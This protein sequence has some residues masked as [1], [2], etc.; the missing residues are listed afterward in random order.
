MVLATRSNNVLHTICL[1]F[2]SGCFHL[3]SARFVRYCFIDEIF[4]I[5][6][7]QKYCDGNFSYWDPKITTPPGLYYLG[8]LYSKLVNLLNIFNWNL[9]YCGTPVLRSLNLVGGLIVFPIL[10][11]NPLLKYNGN[12]FWSSNIIFLPLLSIYYLLFYTDVWSTILIFLSFSTAICLPLGKFKS[13]LLS[14]IISLISVTF[15][16]TNIVWSAFILVMFIDRNAQ[17]S[18]KYNSKT[19]KNNYFIKKIEHFHILETFFINLFGF[20]QQSLEDV[21]CIIPFLINFVLFIGFIIHNGGITFGDKE[22]HIST[23]HLPQLFYC[24]IFITFLSGPL[25][26]SSTFMVLYL[27]N[28]FGSFK[29]LSVT[30]L[31]YVFMFLSVKYFTIVHPFLLADN[32][33]YTFYIWKR[34]IDFKP[35]YSRYAMIPFYHFSGYSLF[36]HLFI[37]LNKFNDTINTQNNKQ[38]RN[39]I[40]IERI[41]KNLKPTFITISAF[42]VSVCATII[43]S[44]LFE[45]RY[46]IL[47]YLFWRVLIDIEST[48][49]SFIDTLFKKNSY[50]IKNFKLHLEFLWFFIINFV[51]IFI[52]INYTFAWD[53]EPGLPQR[54][55]W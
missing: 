36:Y 29:S 19:L 49:F 17:L 21:I 40:V 2:L 14:S 6:Q 33:H 43:P 3:V 35:P 8:F 12:N 15:R 38:N 31:I 5:P 1:V 9:E 11:L 37:N 30:A 20:I 10:C 44:P 46:Y 22:N 26:I 27:K 24:L 13:A 47:P 55:I 7:T 34:V 54:I 48:T 52:F 28:S 18:Q 32:R 45:P 4:H 51:I 39:K 53:T 25:L 42:T 41:N 16:Q 50:E 23:I